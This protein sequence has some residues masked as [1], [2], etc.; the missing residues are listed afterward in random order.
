[1]RATLLFTLRHLTGGDPIDFFTKGLNLKLRLKGL[2]EE[3]S[4]D[5]LLDIILSGLTKAPEFKF[6]KEMHYR[7]EFTS[8][9]RHQ[10]TANRFFVDQQSRNASGPVVSGRGA[11]MA[12][13]SSTVQCHGCQAYGHF[14][15]DCPEAVQQ[16]NKGKK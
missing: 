16:Q 7:D 15:R 1:M 12:A 10:E 5:V 14:Q 13:A 11:A 6:I 2:G 8:V 9:D 4:D 3:V